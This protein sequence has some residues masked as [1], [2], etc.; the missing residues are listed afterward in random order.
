MM[1]PGCVK[2]RR[3]E[4]G[5]GKDIPGQDILDTVYMMVPGCVKARSAGSGKDFEIE[6]IPRQPIF[7]A[8][9]PVWRPRE[10]Q[11]DKKFK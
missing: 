3:A 10:V 2:A 6:I 1:V 11:R 9:S 8:T 4:V 7:Y 5:L